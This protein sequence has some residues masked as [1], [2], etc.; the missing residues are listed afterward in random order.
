MLEEDLKTDISKGL[1]NLK[2]IP[3][4]KMERYTV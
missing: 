2:H 1:T 4:T 3:R